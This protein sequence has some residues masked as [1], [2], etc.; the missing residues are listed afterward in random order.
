MLTQQCVNAL[1]QKHLAEAELVLTI[2]DT[3]WKFTL[4]K[5]EKALTKKAAQ[6]KT[7]LNL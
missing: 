2:L 3:V 4:L 7:T 5:Q 6:A 1:L